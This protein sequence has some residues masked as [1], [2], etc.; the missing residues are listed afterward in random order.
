MGSPARGAAQAAGASWRTRALAAGRGLEPPRQG[1]EGRTVDI[2]EQEQAAVDAVLAA[3]RDLRRRRAILERV[4][5]ISADGD[6]EAL[7]ALR[8]CA[9]ELRVLWVAADRS[10]AVAV[11]RLRAVANG[12]AA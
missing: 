3:R 1:Q 10:E 7:E 11:E 5:R 9:Q 12:G 8:R 2:T 4:E 6:L